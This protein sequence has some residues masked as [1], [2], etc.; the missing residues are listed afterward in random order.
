MLALL[1]ACPCSIN[2]SRFNLPP[3]LV[4][5][6][7]RLQTDRIFDD[8][9]DYIRPQV[10]HP[11]RLYPLS[12]EPNIFWNDPATF[13]R[14]PYKTLVVVFD[15]PDFHTSASE[16]FLLADG[17]PRRGDKMMAA[18]DYSEMEVW[19]AP[20]IEAVVRWLTFTQP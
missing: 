5:T 19:R 1:L 13:R 20:D 3:N 2:S 4:G 9:F 18:Q 15:R 6:L 7:T 14:E 8:P 12:L 16:R 10:P 11:G 17:G